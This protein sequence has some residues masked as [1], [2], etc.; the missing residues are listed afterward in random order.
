MST[1]ASPALSDEAVLSALAE[2]RMTATYKQV[3]QIQQ[4]IAIL[5][6]WNDKI[7]LTAIRDPREILYRHF[8]ESMYA[9][10]AV[11]VEN[12]RLADIGSGGG[13]PGLPIKILRPDLQVF[14]I[15]SNIKKATFL[16]EVSRDL[17]LTD[18]R[19]LVNRFEDVAEDVAPLD[20]VCSRALGEF[21]PFLSWAG[22]QVIAAKMVV[23]WIGARDLDEIQKIEGWTWREPIPVPQSLRRLLL[24][25][26]KAP[27]IDVG[28]TT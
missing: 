7:N 16:A 26:T 21:A 13:F 4:Y 15:E 28:V 6:K 11:P 8:C 20:Y 23:L 24:V 18:L 17:E 19:V 22:S 14:L 10:V 3:Q 1:P 9:A 2:F 12:G 27:P 25:G 5:L